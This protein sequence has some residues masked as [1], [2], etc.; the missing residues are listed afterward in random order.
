MRFSLGY[1]FISV[2]DG[3]LDNF[4][5]SLYTLQ[6]LSQLSIFLL[7]LDVLEEEDTSV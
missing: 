6:L 1:G 4:T 3:L 2:S 7:Q 5:L